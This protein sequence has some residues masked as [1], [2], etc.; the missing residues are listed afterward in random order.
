MGARR[1]L[2]DSSGM[3]ITHKVDYAVR[4]VVA[5]A[6][7]EKEHPGVPVKGERLATGEAI[8]RKFL[9]DILRLLRNAQLVRSHRGPE[10]GWTLAR[11]PEQ[12][13]VAE[14]IRVL[15]GPL[16]SVRGIRPHELPADGVAEPFVS[17]WIAVRV[18][19]R[20]VLEHVTVADLAAGKLPREVAALLKAPDAWIAH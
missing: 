13:T 2:E 18:A 3:R 14:I 16:A 11:P 6:R 5:L 4:A 15:E 7:I 12:I 1:C 8:P 19:L 9:D 20:S 17:L 10:G